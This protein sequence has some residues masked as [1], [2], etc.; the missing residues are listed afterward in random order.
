MGGGFRR[1]ENIHSRLRHQ[2][3][4]LDN[5]GTDIKAGRKIDNPV[6]ADDLDIVWDPDTVPFQI[7]DDA[8]GKTVGVTEDAVK[9]ETAVMKMFRQE[10]VDRS[11]GLFIIDAEKLIFR[12]GAAAGLFKAGAAPVRFALNLGAD[13]QEEKSAAAELSEDT[14]GISG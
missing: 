2:A 6:I 11:F 9:I 7:I 3:K 1:E 10:A 14:Q 13:A 8:S 12:P 5:G 4:R